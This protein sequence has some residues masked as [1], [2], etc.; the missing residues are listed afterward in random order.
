LSSRAHVKKE[1]VYYIGHT[2][3][4]M[5]HLHTFMRSCHPLAAG[6]VNCLH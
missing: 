3:L 5:L 2:L 1:T 6:E 4:I